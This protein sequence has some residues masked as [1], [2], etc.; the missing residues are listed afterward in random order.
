MIYE[1]TCTDCSF[2]WEEEQKITE[3]AKTT[4]P[5]CLQEKAKRLISKSSF[6]LNGNGWG[7]EGYGNK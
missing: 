7:N 3:N 6:I 4:C 2:E 1:Y 5:K